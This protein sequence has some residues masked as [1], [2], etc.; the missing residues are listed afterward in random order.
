MNFQIENQPASRISRHFIW[1]FNCLT[2]LCR[3]H[4]DILKAAWKVSQRL[5]AAIVA[6]LVYSQMVFD[7]KCIQ[8]MFQCKRQNVVAG[9]AMNNKREFS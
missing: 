8:V 5:H 4:V 2:F 7:S 1:I 9:L 6:L 3:K